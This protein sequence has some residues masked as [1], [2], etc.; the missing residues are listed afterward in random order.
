[1]WD[2]S[3]RDGGGGDV[4]IDAGAKRTVELDEPCAAL[5]VCDC[6]RRFLHTRLM[7]QQLGK[8]KASINF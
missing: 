1:M 5:A 3:G 2:C 4:V 7:F 6:D 8:I